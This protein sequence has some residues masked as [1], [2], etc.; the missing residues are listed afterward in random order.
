MSEQYSLTDFE[1]FKNAVSVSDNHCLKYVRQQS[2][3]SE[4]IILTVNITYDCLRRWHQA[5][6]AGALK[7][8]KF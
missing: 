2:V 6:Q 1:K 5:K 8:V 3:S 4:D 7:Q